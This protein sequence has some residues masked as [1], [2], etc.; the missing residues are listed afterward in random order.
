MNSKINYALSGRDLSDLFDDKIK[1]VNYTDLRKC[2]SIKEL[3]EPYNRTII[4]YESKDYWGHWCCIWKFNNEIH[5]FDSFST[6]PDEQI[7]NINSNYRIKK[8]G[9]IPHLTYLLY[10][11]DL[12]IRYNN[13]KL[14]QYGKNI[15]T[16]GRWVAFRL[17]CYF[18]NEDEFYNLFKDIKDKDYMITYLTQNIP[19]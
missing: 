16:C 17:M 12:P 18:M 1:I 5:F 6:F 10:K 9:K 3:L 19:D 4:L 2:R 11:C 14:Q 8:Y 7:K 15:N 13:Y